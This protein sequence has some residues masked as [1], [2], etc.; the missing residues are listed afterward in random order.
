MPEA[1]VPASHR[2]LLKA[3]VGVLATVGPDGYP[4]ASAVWFLALDDGG[5]VFSLNTSRQKSKNLRRRPECS[6]LIVDPASPYRTLELRGR[7]EIAPDPEYATADRVFAKYGSQ[8]NP[9][10][11]DKPGESRLAVT[12]RPEK[13]NVWGAP[14]KE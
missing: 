9:R 12:L 2:D 5:V 14:A 8:M 10:Q 7:V 13:V 4:Q 6:F 3:P 1:T 11:M